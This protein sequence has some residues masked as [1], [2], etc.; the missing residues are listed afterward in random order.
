MR[1]AHLPVV[2]MASLMLIL[3]GC[4]GGG[5]G[6][7]SSSRG[8]DGSYVFGTGH[9]YGDNLSYVA[10]GDADFS[11]TSLDIN[12][13]ETE[14]DSIDSPVG[15]VFFNSHNLATVDWYGDRNTIANIAKSA[16]DQ[17]LI[18]G[19]EDNQGGS[20]MGFGIQN[21]FS[22]ADE[23]LANGNYRF[24]QL[25][26]DQRNTGPY[27]YSI[28]EDISLS[29]DG[30]GYS[31][32]DDGTFTFDDEPLAIGQISAD[33]SVIAMFK[34]DA[35]DVDD[36]LVYISLAIKQS[37]GK[38]SD[39]LVGNTYN[40]L[41]L[42]GEDTQPI[43]AMVGYSTIT[44]NTSDSCTIIDIID[45]DGN[46]PGTCIYSIAADGS[47]EIEVGEDPEGDPDNVVLEGMVSEDNQLFSVVLPNDPNDASPDIPF[48]VIGTLQP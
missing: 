36:D 37:S 45:D 27:L 43:N 15:A 1:I 23:T 20:G 9:G 31:I 47:F 30:T 41:R 10:F 8:F 17:Y 24:L 19:W 11:G 2:L 22:G 6:G 16:N 42:G 3:T 38:L 13:I 25:I 34:Y 14:G 12:A 39:A 18:I 5:G 32:D 33:G 4:G 21:E 28:I 46:N 35:G 26:D 7:S 29:G 44:F 48:I 40:M